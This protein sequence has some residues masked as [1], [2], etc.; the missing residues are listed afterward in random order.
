MGERLKKPNSLLLWLKSERV[1]LLY[2]F[3][4]IKE[5]V[6]LVETI[7]LICVFTLSH[8]EQNPFVTKIMDY[9]FPI[10]LLY[11]FHSP[12]PS[13]FK[14]CF[15]SVLVEL[16]IFQ[17]YPYNHCLKQQVFLN[18]FLFFSKQYLQAGPSWSRTRVWILARVELF[19]CSI[20]E[21]DGGLSITHIGDYIINY[22]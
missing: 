3:L 5:W 2:M 1:P 7:S 4:Q 20:L 10:R 12:L 14:N 18:R 8:F 17:F 21:L 6:F 22:K 19:I 15:P 16:I 13:L 11:Y 9:Y